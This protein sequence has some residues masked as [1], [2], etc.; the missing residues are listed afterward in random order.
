MLQSGKGADHNIFVRR[1]LMA[2]SPRVSDLC[3]SGGLLQT[4]AE[5][6]A[7]DRLALGVPPRDAV[8]RRRARWRL[9]SRRAHPPATR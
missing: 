1:K 3:D 5:I 6:V 9:R 7:P 8:P 4:E 2:I